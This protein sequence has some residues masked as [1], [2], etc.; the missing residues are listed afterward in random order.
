[1]AFAII[2]LTPTPLLADG[3]IPWVFLA[4]PLMIVGL[5]PVIL[6]ESFVL[7]RRL[8]LGWSRALRVAAIV[9]LASTVVGV[10][11][12]VVLANTPLSPERAG[13][14]ILFVMLVPLFLVSWLVEYPIAWYMLRPGRSGSAV[15]SSTAAPVGSKPTPPRPALCLLNHPQV[16]SGTF[17]A[18]VASYLFLAAMVV[19]L[20]ALGFRNHP[21]YEARAKRQ[22]SSPVESL[23]AIQRAEAMYAETYPKKLGFSRSLAALGGLEEQSNLAAARSAGEFDPGLASSGF[24]GCPTPTPELACLIDAQ[25]A[26]GAKEGYRFTY[27]PH[28]SNDGVIDSYSIS[29][30]PISGAGYRRYSIDQKGT[31]RVSNGPPATEADKRLPE[32]DRWSQPR[33]TLLLRKINSAEAKYSSMFSKGFS[34][35]LEDLGGEQGCGKPTEIAACLIDTKLAYGEDNFFP[36]YRFVFSP[37]RS[38]RGAIRSYSVTASSKKHP[39]GY[40]YYTDQTGVIRENKRAPATAADMPAADPTAV[41]LLNSLHRAEDAYS[42]VFAKTFSPSLAALGHSS[43]HP[44]AGLI[45]AELA[46]GQKICGVTKDGSSVAKV[47]YRFTYKPVSQFW[48]GKFTEYT[49]RARPDTYLGLYTPSFIAHIRLGEKPQGETGIEMTKEDRE[50]T[51]D[52]PPVVGQG[53]L[54]SPNCPWPDTYVRRIVLAEQD[55]SGQRPGS[56]TASLADLGRPSA[57]PAEP[58]ADAAGLIDDELSSGQRPWY[59]EDVVY[60]YSYVPGPS[61]AGRI[62]HYTVIARPLKYIPDK[63][64]GY[65]IDETGVIRRTWKDRDA[66]ANDRSIDSRDG[67]IFKLRP[68]DGAVLGSYPVP[69]CGWNGEC[70]L[71]FDGANVWTAVWTFDSITKLRASDGVN[72]GTFSPGS[73]PSAM[74]SDGTNIWGASGANGNNIVWK[75]RASDGAKLGTFTVGKSADGIAFDGTNM[76]VSNYSDGTVTKL[77]ATDGVTLGTFPAGYTPSCMTSDGSN[78]WVVNPEGN[79]VTELRASDGTTLRT[80]SVGSEPRGVAFD[81]ASIWVAN[82]GSDSVSKLRASD[83]AK[84]GTFRVPGPYYLA[85]DGA[86]IWVTS[87]NAGIVTKLRASDGARLGTFTPSPT[88]WEIVFDGANIWVGGSEPTH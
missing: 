24:Q 65:F 25:F 32:V 29:A 35:M 43:S 6:I 75:L 84:L 83:G 9:N 60:R 64:P 10:V 79:T 18:N 23:Q 33:I 7:R 4:P 56:Y 21:D 30:S 38:V 44:Q 57:R 76:W 72:L 17:T 5:I 47:L 52:D 68:S 34:P 78:I 26:G 66:T 70:E 19:I 71:V 55:Y 2:V 51:A 73:A 41:L 39:Y 14:I 82:H 88:P 16:R 77:R 46:T 54:W 28:Q 12:V 59:G 20:L 13:P 8:D 27:T 58:S 69:N 36:G 50:A 87:F 11:G 86:N 74:A 22:Q 48:T 40:Y 53:C 42:N 49:L 67:F 80:I 3:A 31:I 37:G 62:R 61:E 81:G 85:F 63:T 1:M 45:D 15:L